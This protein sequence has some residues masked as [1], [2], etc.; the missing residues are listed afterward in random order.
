MLSHQLLEHILLLCAGI[1]VILLLGDVVIRNAVALAEHY[2]LSGSFIGLTVLSVGTSIP[3]LMTHLIAS[4]HILSDPSQMDTLSAL[5]IG[6]NIGSDIIQQDLLL[7]VIGL[8]GTV[9]VVRAE[10]HMQ[11]GA[12]MAAALLLWVFALDGQISRAEGALL[13][14]A[15]FGY[16][17]Y[18]MRE[19]HIIDRVV[20]QR[21]NTTG[22]PILKLVIILI[23]FLIMA[24]AADRVVAAAVEL[25]AV[26]PISASLFGVL[27]L[28]VATAL[29]ELITALLSMAKGHNSISA[30][31]LIGSNVTN[32][33][34]G[35]G[36][37]AVV[38]EYTVPNVVNVYDLPFKIFTAGLLYVFLL[39]HEDLNRREAATLIL[40][41]LVYLFM[42]PIWFPG[43]AVI[44]G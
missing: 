1:A 15:Y 21:N 33:L 37:G 18:L 17:L 13:V 14:I 4:A 5:V 2:H 41:C 31:I 7:P 11:I 24:I 27:V 16:L 34:M 35:V 39:R 29:P 38:S 44:I 9:L 23:C 42:R 20:A 32:P 40:L 28:G 30:E 43:D 19:N 25:V 3:E 8:I 6:S 22:R 12:L 10:V 26:L 36:L